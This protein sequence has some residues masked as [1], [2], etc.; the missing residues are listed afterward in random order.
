MMTQLKDSSFMIKRVYRAREVKQSYITSVFTT[1]VAIA[2]SFVIVWWSGAD[3]VVSNGPGT[4]VPLRYA[5]WL[6]SKL[7]GLSGKIL[8]IESFCRVESLSL[9]GRLVKP[10]T[11]KFIVHW[12]QLKQKNPSVT[13]MKDYKLL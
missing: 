2:H 3:L 8:F 5:H 13:Y 7:I 9:T 6:F 12:P 1:L 4:A 10:I 11:T